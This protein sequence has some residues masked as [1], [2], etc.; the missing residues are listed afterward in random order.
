MGKPAWKLLFDT[1]E[2]YCTEPGSYQM[3]NFNSFTKDNSF[4]A[5]MEVDPNTGFLRHVPSVL[6]RELYN[7]DNWIPLVNWKTSADYWEHNRKNENEY[8]SNSTYHVSSKINA[9]SAPGLLEITPTST[10]LS[11]NVLAFGGGADVVEMEVSVAVLSMLLNFDKVVPVAETKPGFGLA[12]DESFRIALKVDK[13]ADTWFYNMFYCV[14]DNIGLHLTSDGQLSIYYYYD[15]NPNTPILFDRFEICKPGDIDAKSIFIDIIPVPGYGL[16]ISTNVTPRRTA[17]VSSSADRSVRNGKLVKIPQKTSGGYEYCYD[18]TPITLWTIPFDKVASDEGN[19]LGIHMRY[20]WGINRIRFGGTGK[21]MSYVLDAGHKFSNESSLATFFMIKQN[22]ATLTGRVTNVLFA[23]KNA[24]AQALG[25]P[26]VRV[27][28]LTQQFRFLIESQMPA[29]SLYTPFYTGAQF[30]FQRVAYTRETTPVE[31][32]WSK[33]EYTVEDSGAFAGT[34]STVSNSPESFF[35]TKRGDTTW[36]LL[37]TTDVEAAEPEWVVISGGIAK[38]TGSAYRTSSDPNT[39]GFGTT[40][41]APTHAPIGR[42]YATWQLY[43]RTY[44]LDEIHQFKK[45]A[46][47]GFKYREAINLMLQSSGED[48]IPTADFPPEF[49]EKLPSGSSILNFKW[50]TNPG[51]SGVKVIDAMLKL[52]KRQWREFQFFYSWFFGKWM[53][54]PKPKNEATTYYLTPFE[55]ERSLPN[56]IKV[57]IPEAECFYPFPPEA[58]MIQAIGVLDNDEKTSQ[59]ASPNFYSVPS[60][61]DP[62]SLDYLGRAKASKILIEEISS[63]PIATKIARQVY[64]YVADWDANFLVLAQGYDPNFSPINHPKCVVRL[65]GP[66]GT[67]QDFLTGWLKKKIVTINA[68][69]CGY[70]VVKY[71]VG[72]KWETVRKSSF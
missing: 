46:L 41:A 27:P 20:T 40:T 1:P 45:A 21:A 49:E 8:N 58:N 65:A 52:A 57:S 67:R 37:H 24:N 26:T 53:I 10:K 6:T 14:F 12:K 17:V 42:L 66:D 4:F 28:P 25:T 32:A 31:M 15:T 54:T 13:D 63:E 19:L 33:I 62:T 18:A 34:C 38:C 69:Q 64:D 60:F 11:P 71:I 16:S 72:K 29:N 43:P 7:E 30:N 23:D 51:D 55:D 22:P 2:T 70:E 47:D 44:V 61:Y 35:I 68:G 50:V 36:R 56:R 48:P 5:N 3:L 39:A 9:D 59:I